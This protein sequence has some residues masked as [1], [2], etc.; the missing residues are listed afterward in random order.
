MNE[1]LGMALGLV[2]L[3]FGAEALVKG[4][5]GLALRLGLTPLVI[6]LTV[7]AFGTS[8]PEMV[9]SVQATLG[10]NGAISVGNVVGSNI[11]NIALILGL[12]ALISPMR[13]DLQVI[14]REVPIMIGV[15]VFALLI[16][17]DGRVARWEG[18][19]LL[20]SLIAY[21]AITVRQARAATAA[22]VDPAVEKEFSDE[23][24][25]DRPRGLAFSIVSVIGGLAVLIVGSHFFVEA[26]VS[27]ATK[28]GMSQIAIGLTIVAVGTSLPELATSLLAAFKRQGDVAIGNVVG[29]NIF[30]V[31]GILG[32]AALL[33]PIDVPAL[34]WVDLGVML[35]V[36][37]AL[38]PVVRSGGR[39][40][41]GE[42]A[43][44]LAAYIGY[45]WW[46]LAQ[47]G[48]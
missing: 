13:A 19:L 44:L 3:Y 12:C 24:G 28:W 29:S 18:A 10:G 45:T 34:S 17:A 33:R 11:C 20:L 26:A 23:V 30:N 14:R 9:V 1:W 2:A 27:L 21:T 46:L 5:A 31:L 43:L 47:S 32:V 16:L 4:G 6:G 36:S 25:Q 39:I 41:R 38:L 22:G 8:S 40:S 35:G 48:A 37:I 15:S 42:G 7:I